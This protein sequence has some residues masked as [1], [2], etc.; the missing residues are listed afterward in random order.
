MPG[1]VSVQPRV[2]GGLLDTVMKGMAVA[3]DVYGIQNE[4]AHTD[5]LNQQAEQGKQ[6]FEDEQAGVFTP[7]ERVALGKNYDFVSPDTANASKIGVRSAPGAAGVAD[8][9]I[10]PKK[11]LSP[12]QQTVQDAIVNGKH[13]TAT[14]DLNPNNVDDDGNHPL[15]NFVETQKPDKPVNAHYVA[16]GSTDPNGN[17]IVLDTTTGQGKP[18]DAGGI[19]LNNPKAD[20]AAKKASDQE[21][22]T[23]TEMV[24]KINNPGRNRAVQTAQLNLLNIANANELISQYPD[25]NQM[26]PQKVALLNAE[27]AKISSGGVGSEH[28]QEAL[29]A[30]TIAEKFAKFKSEIGGEPNGAQVGAFIQQ[31]KDYLTGLQKVSQAKVDSYSKEMYGS[32]KHRLSP[33][34]QTR[35]ETEH[36]D[37]FGGQQPQP[38]APV[39]QSSGFVGT[40]NAGT[41]GGAPAPHAQD[42][43]ALK[44]ANENRLSPDPTTAGMAM[45]ILQVNG[46]GQ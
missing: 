11:E 39:A 28:G 34:L 14:Y 30:N 33:E 3:R 8:A 5:L 37:L 27:L 42:A 9:Y 43:T 19:Q 16:T 45:K 40:A 32:Y 20:A 6:Q 7:K 18:I 15:M 36:A 22:K 24:G 10:L 17:P 38:N 25:L 4:S 44:W 41:G 26:P 1:V 13:G 21:E 35:F 23:Y 29:A 12:I 2:Q 31:N 46:G